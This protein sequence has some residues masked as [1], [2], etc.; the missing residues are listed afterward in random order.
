VEEERVRLTVA[1]TPFA[2]VLELMPEATQIYASAP[3]AQDRDLP[4]PVRDA[5]GVTLIDATDAVG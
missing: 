2:T 1:T 5:P 4:A 3:P